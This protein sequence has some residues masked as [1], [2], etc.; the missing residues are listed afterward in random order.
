MIART[1]GGSSSTSATTASETKRSRW[2]P[3]VGF[4]GGASDPTPFGLL[5][6]R[7]VVRCSAM[8]PKLRSSSGGV[9][10]GSRAPDRHAQSFAFRR[11]RDRVCGRTYRRRQRADV[12]SRATDP[13][14]GPDA[15]IRHRRAR[16]SRARLPVTLPSITYTYGPAGRRWVLGGST[17]GTNRH[18]AGAYVY[19]I[20]G[21]VKFV[22]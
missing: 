16:D 3:G 13:V 15:R 22:V 2:I 5:M 12:M 7:C 10:K 8:E 14:G 6:M 20:D 4:V 18:P 1:T 17:P 19:V 21:S 9:E 11:I